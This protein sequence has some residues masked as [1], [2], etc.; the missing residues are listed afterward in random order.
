MV[1]IRPFLSKG[2]YEEKMVDNYSCWYRYYYRRMHYLL[3]AVLFK[4]GMLR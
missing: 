3:Q 2:E 1:K 4:M